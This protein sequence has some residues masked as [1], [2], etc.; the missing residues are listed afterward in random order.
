MK[1]RDFFKTT[2]VSGSTLALAGLGACTTEP[3]NVI[4]VNPVDFD[5]NEVTI[6]E[7]Q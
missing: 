7:L 1:R 2:A 5:L 4:K 3:E 6:D